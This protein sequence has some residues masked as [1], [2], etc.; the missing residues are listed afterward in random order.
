MLA[1]E[2]Q[3]KILELVRQNNIVKVSSLSQLFQTTETTI[4]RDLDELQKD[5]KI[6]RVHGGAV[7]LK[8]PQ[9]RSDRR[10]TLHHMPGRKRKNRQNR[11]FIYRRSRFAFSGFFVY[12]PA[13]G[14]TSADQR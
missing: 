14:Q 12:R 4:R 10:G 6:R 3:S 5:K 7:P 11:N 1:Q 2:R 13:A 8:K 9:Q